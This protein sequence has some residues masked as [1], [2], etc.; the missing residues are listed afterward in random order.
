MAA[1]QPAPADPT[2]RP[3]RAR[4]PQQSCP[5]LESLGY[6][7]RR[8]ND[9]RL[10][11]HLDDSE[12]PADCSTELFGTTQ[13]GGLHRG[14]GLQFSWIASEL[15]HQPLYFED[16]ILERA[17]QTH[18]HL[19]Q[20]WLSGAH[21]FGTFPIIPYKIGLDRL[22]DRVYVLGYPRPGTPNPSLGRRLPFE[23][24]AAGFEAATWLGLL[25]VLP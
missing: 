19:V 21:F 18:H 23:L 11:I 12:M 24:D 17:G 3:A 6:Q 7:F 25:F 2:V 14:L 13:Q 22:H 8:L 1:V 15:Y 10:S 4:I 20:P 16:P 9:I 5:S